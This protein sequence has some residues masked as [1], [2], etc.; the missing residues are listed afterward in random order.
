M[1]TILDLKQ[2]NFIN[3]FLK[4]DVNVLIGIV[5]RDPS[6]ATYMFETISDNLLKVL[7]RIEA[8]HTLIDEELSVLFGP[9][10]S[11]TS[12]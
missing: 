4:L 2:C 3:K 10:G 1:E 9:E 12:G 5:K 11:W 6:I 8:I 7:D